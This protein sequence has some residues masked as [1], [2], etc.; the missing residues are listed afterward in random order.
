MIKKNIEQEKRMDPNALFALSYG[1][2]MIS[3]RD[4]ARH[5]G[6]INNTLTQQTAS[7]LQVSVTLQKTGFTH[8]L[9]R[10]NGR[11]AASVLSESAVFPLFQHFGFQS[12]RDAEKFDGSFPWAEDAQ[13]LPY[14]TQMACARFSCLVTRTADLGTHTWFLAE[15]L[16]AQRLLPESPLTYAD[17]HA[18]IKPRP[19]QALPAAAGKS[20]WRCKICGHEVEIEGDVLPPDYVCPLCKHGALDFERVV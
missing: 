3:A 14:L 10:A 15:V 12:G 20:R 4:G 6:M 17:Y 2:Y 8:E 13:G 5:S 18:H 11:F 19:Q 7:P 16:D 1:L 9:I